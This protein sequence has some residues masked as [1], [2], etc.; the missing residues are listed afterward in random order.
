MPTYP[1]LSPS[2][3]VRVSRAGALEL[4][5]RSSNA[6]L[7]QDSLLARHPSTVRLLVT[8]TRMRPGPLDL[9]PQQAT[10]ASFL[11]EPLTLP[12]TH[13]AMRLRSTA[14]P[15]SLW[16]ASECLQE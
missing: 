9:A 11:T 10:G 4:G 3:S 2:I 6:E 8:L 16:E 7:R 5:R 1:G 14:G 12:M 15:Q 13:S